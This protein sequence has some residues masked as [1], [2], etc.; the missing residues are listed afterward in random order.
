MGPWSDIAKATVTILGPLFAGIWFLIK[1]WGAMAEKVKRLQAQEVLTSVETLKTELSDTKKYLNAVSKDLQK[2]R[3]E[4]VAIRTRLQ[5]TAESG[6]V[7]VLKVDKMR[8]YTEARLHL[9]EATLDDGEILKIGANRFMF[10]GRRK[11][12]ED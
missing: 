4:L 7:F 12:E 6:E 8:E 1:R 5:M 3:E 10:K 11:T 9:M 2:S